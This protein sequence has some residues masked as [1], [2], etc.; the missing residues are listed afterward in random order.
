M[1]LRILQIICSKNVKLMMINKYKKIVIKIGSSSIVNPTTKKIN[2]K[3]MDKLCKDIEKYHKE[4]NIIIVCSGAIALGST[5][6]KSNKNL[7]KLEDKQA[8]ASVGQIE[9]AHQWRQHLK[10][11]K[12]NIAQVLITLEDSEVRRRYLNARKTINTLLQKKIIPVINENDTVATEEIRYGDND[13]LAARVA[14][15]IDADLLVLLSDVDGLYDK[16]PNKNKD[17]KKINEIFKIN[18]FIEKMANAQKSSLGSG[19]MITKIAAAKICMNNGCDTIITNSDKTHPLSSIAKK[20]SSIFFSDKNPSSSRKQWLLNHLHSS[21]FIRI[22]EGALKA[23]KNNKSLLPAGI[24]EVGGN[25]NRGDVIS[26]YFSKKNKI[27]IGISAYDINE[28]KK[29]IGKKSKEI[30]NIL[31]YEG[32]DEIIHKD[33]LVKII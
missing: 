2:S 1:D 5:L 31:G 10:K 6:I 28:A 33:D 21:G 9:L 23:V 15:M 4:K 12:I 14:Q 32:R 8:A 26:V 3:L 18:K 13:R 19:G 7:R 24:T 30:P 17:A 22:D 16:N 20:N 29:I 25:F 11:H 27:A